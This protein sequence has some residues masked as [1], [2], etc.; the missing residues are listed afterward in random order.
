MVQRHSQNRKG[1]SAVLYNC[2]AL[3]GVSRRGLRGTIKGTVTSHWP[4][5]FNDKDFSAPW[6][7]TIPI[8]NCDGIEDDTLALMD[9]ARTGIRFRQPGSAFKCL[10]RAADLGD[11]DARTAI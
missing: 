4:G 10:S 1:R 2:R 7:A 11:R 6:T 3:S 9:V 5:H 8:T